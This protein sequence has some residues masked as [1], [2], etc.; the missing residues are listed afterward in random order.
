[1]YPWDSPFREKWYNKSKWIE[2]LRKNGF[3]VE[4]IEAIEGEG[5]KF[6]NRYFFVRSR[7]LKE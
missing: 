7:K 2:I 5:K 6:V 3:K 1:M 4:T